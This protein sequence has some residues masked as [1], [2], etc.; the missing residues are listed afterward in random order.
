MRRWLPILAVIAGFGS[1]ISSSLQAQL[2]G[3]YK[4]ED[5]RVSPNLH[6][7]QSANVSGIVLDG[8]GVAFTHISLQIQNPR[9]AK[10]LLTATVDEKGRFDFGYVPP[11]EFRLVPVQIL[12]GKFI[13]VPGFDPPHSVTCSS[14]KICELRITL[15]TRPTDLPYA[16]CPPK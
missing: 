4:C 14:D 2:V 9:N 5:E 15:P 16:N 12:N 11:G 7:A 10:P 13:K 8:S 1:F 6:V 3:S